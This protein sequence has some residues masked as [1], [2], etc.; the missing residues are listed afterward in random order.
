MSLKSLTDYYAN[1]LAYQYRGLPRAAAQIRLWTKQVL[2][3]FLANDVANAFDIDTAVGK[4][5]DVIGKYVGVPRN[6]GLVPVRPYFGFWSRYHLDT[7]TNTLVQSNYLGTWSPV[8]NTPPL[9]NET[10][11]SGKW[12]IA[13]E[14]GTASFGT[15]L[16]GDAITYNGSVWVKDSTV[17][18]NGFTT[19]SNPGVNA[20][21]IFYRAAFATGQN[22][23][24]TDEQYR[25]VIKLKT[26]LNGND[27]TLA[28]VMA[29]LNTFFPGQITLTDNRD[30]SLTYTVLSTVALSKE[31]LA[32]Y[33]PKPMGVGITVTIISPLPLHEDITTENDSIITT[34][35]GGSIS[36]S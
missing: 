4:Q 32:V 26:V 21:G 18:G 16:A 27:G 28:S 22:T 17:N 8:T 15:F 9:A 5:L 36:T 25:T 20:N 10:G 7:T 11:T 35:S 1:L 23:D 29:Y 3:D 30:M 31:L 12:Y 19:Y 6:I 24:L 33:L 2:A 34:E 13:S 14:S